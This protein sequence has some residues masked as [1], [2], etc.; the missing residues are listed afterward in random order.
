MSGYNLE[1]L[2]KLASDFFINKENI[3]KQA[4]LQIAEM[5]KNGNTDKLDELLKVIDS[6]KVNEKE[7][8][9][10]IEKTNKLHNAN[11]DNK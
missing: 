11:N 9:E 4:N 2:Q 7:L 3:M 6:A 10:L 5:Q 1:E 8:E